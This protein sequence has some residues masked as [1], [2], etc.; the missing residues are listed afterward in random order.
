MNNG[1][2]AV[3]ALVVTAAALMGIAGYE[4]YRGAAYLDSGKVP[5][6]G[7]GATQG[8]KMGDTTTPARA[9]IRLHA[10]A[11][12][13]ARAIGRCIKAPLYQYEFDAYLSLAFN[14]GAGAFCRG[15]APDQPPTLIDLINAE[16]Y[17]EA[18]ARIA[19]FDK[20]RNPNTGRLEALPGL[21]K[22]RLSEQRTCMGAKP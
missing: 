15:A 22:R 18:C 8:V 19:Q 5:T 17:A 11:S 21:T 16:R 14:I 4:D 6:L 20:Y 7:Y 10:D 1:R 9:L 2:T 3:T 12:E 13:H